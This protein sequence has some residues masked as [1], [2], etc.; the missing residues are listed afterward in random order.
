MVAPV[1]EEAVEQVTDDAPQVE[2]VAPDELETVSEADTPDVEESDSPET[3]PDAEVE[4]ELSL[5]DP[6]IAE[7]LTERL[8]VE[9]NAGAQSREAELRKT[10]GNDANQQARLKVYA[11]W[12][13]EHG[14]DPAKLNLIIQDRDLHAIDAAVRAVGEQALT[15]VGATSAQIE[16]SQAKLENTSRDDLQKFA[17][18]LLVDATDAIK[19][20]VS[21]TLTLDEVPE[22]STLRTE[23]NAEVQRLFAD[24]MK[25]QGIKAKEDGS[26][27]APA[28]PAGSPA[29]E[30]GDPLLTKLEQE[31][32][33]GLT[34]EELQQAFEKLGLKAT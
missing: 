31:G 14:S 21:S 17:S 4:T 29:T 1:V 8:Q 12:A 30:G 6:R 19:A 32:R 23:I 25:A 22:D 13:L 2:A 9:R 27:P 18:E 20:D 33:A 26:D 3:V 11:D 15:F 5:D 28:V 34:P 7:A 24:E 10:Q 16:R